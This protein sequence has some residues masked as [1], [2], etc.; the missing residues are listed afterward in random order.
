MRLDSADIAEKVERQKIDVAQ[1][2]SAHESA[3]SNLEI[4]R[5]QNASDIR[6]AQLDVRFGAPRPRAVC[7]K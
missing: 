6:K 1:S 4:Q 2:R 7:R 5:Q 3:V